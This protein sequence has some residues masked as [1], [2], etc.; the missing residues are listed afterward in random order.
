VELPDLRALLTPAGQ[1]ALAA[2]EARQPAEPDF[3]AHFQALSR[4][5]PPALARAALETAILRREAAAKFPPGVA[6]QLYLT[7]EALQQASPWEVAAHRAARF[8]GYD[9]TLDLGC[10]IGADTIHLAQVGAGLAP[11]L[12]LDRDPLR[13]ALARLHL[14]ALGL[15]AE[16]IRADLTSPL[17]FAPP[18]LRAA[19]LFFDPAR[20]RGHRRIFSVRNYS[21]PLDVIRNWRAAALGVKISPGVDLA[22]LAG[23]D[24]E[25]EFTS[26]HGELKEAGLWFG[27]FRSAGS[28]ATL[29]P[30]G[31]TLAAD[32]R[33]GTDAQPSPLSPPRRYLYEPDPAVIRAGLV[34]ALAGQLGA[35]QLDASIAYLTADRRVDTP[36]ARAWQVED[37][38]PFNLKNLRA[39]LRAR[40][41]GRVTV[42]K[43]GSPLT[44]EKLIADLKLHGEEQRA[45]VLTRLQGEPVVLVCLPP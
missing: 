36:F 41:V 42:K 35:A 31:H 25:I 39:H 33:P 3:L 5:H 7:R 17:P 16:F 20:R 38:L 27:A 44:P 19:A 23:Y 30:G 21:P 13:L 18:R 4:Q 26:L 10:S 14:A 11:A 12:G 43:R 29:L 2:A 32:G 15:P 22:E 6:R 37:W 8:R 24:C 28:R 40:N 1:R 34:G 45:L 9:L